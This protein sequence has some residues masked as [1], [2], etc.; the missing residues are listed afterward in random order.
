MHHCFGEPFIGLIHIFGQ[1]L[2][3]LKSHFFLDQWVV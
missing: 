3:L 2:E 1:I